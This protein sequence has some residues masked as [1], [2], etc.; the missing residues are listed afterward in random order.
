M[1]NNDSIQLEWTVKEQT[2]DD[3]DRNIFPLRS[4]ILYFTIEHKKENPGG[5]TLLLLCNN[6]SINQLGKVST[7]NKT[8]IHLFEAKT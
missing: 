4:S 8:L 2:L 3:K 6:D 5:T 1:R 7:I